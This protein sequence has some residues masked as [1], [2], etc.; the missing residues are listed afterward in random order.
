MRRTAGAALAV[1][2]TAS[3]AIALSSD[4][5]AT[6]A[7]DPCAAWMDPGKPAAKRAEALVAAMSTEQKLHMVTFG[8][9][10]WFLYYG[11]AGH[12]TGIPELCIPDLILSDA[13]SGVAG[14]QYG[15][16]TFPS[17]VAQAAT[18]DPSVQRLVGRTIG[19]EAHA[20]GINVML[21]PGMNIARTPYNGR[22]FEY[23]GEDPFLASQTAVAVIRGIQQKKAGE[24]PRQLKGFEK[25]RL[26]PGQSKRVTVTLS[27]RAF[28]Y[29]SNVKDHWVIT[30]GRY[31]VFAGPDSRTLPLRAVLR[32]AAG[33]VAK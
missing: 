8:D 22:N 4:P 16:T 10:P 3:T 33:S 23:F 24:P 7:P 19:A 21:G 1:I 28:A 20:K 14:M 15:T 5:A 29:W 9:P 26:A 32:L 25:V 27:P 30:P 31:R 6:V 11:V 17:G 18:W 2:L 13:G 12:V